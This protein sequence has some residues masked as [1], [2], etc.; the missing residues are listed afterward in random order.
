MAR[1]TL[2]K[3]R[4]VAVAL[5]VAFTAFLLY[6]LGL[7]FMVLW[8]S[9]RDP[10]SSAFMDA[11]RRELQTENP[12]ATIH[13]QWVP[14]AQISTNLKRAVIASEDAN[15]MDHEGVEWAAIRRAW[16]YNRQQADKGKTKMRGG[17][18][19]TQQLAKNL[20]LSSSRSYFRK[21]QE[22]VLTYMMEAVMSKERILE[23]YLNVAQWGTNVFGAQAAAKHYYKTDAARL[24]ARQ[25]AQL[26]AMLPN[27]AYYDKNRNTRYLRGRTATL[28]KRMR[29]VT[30]P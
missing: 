11:T 23:L 13:Y 28:Q 15:F 17:S 10:A 2:N 4:I 24:G 5:L 20:F 27:P 18:T 16:E 9:V 21:G 6:Q 8:L 1:R 3:T 26:A 19:I 25:A 22:L 12:E 14:Y 30:V 29:M 7:F